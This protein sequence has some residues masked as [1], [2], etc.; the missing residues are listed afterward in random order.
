[1]RRISPS[2]SWQSLPSLSMATSQAYG[3]A[4]PASTS[5]WLR[6]NAAPCNAAPSSMPPVTRAAAAAAGEP[7]P[8]QLDTVL[9][10]DDK[11]GGRLGVRPS[12][13]AVLDVSFNAPLFTHTHTHTPEH[14]SMPPLFAHSQKIPRTVP[15]PAMPTPFISVDSAPTSHRRLGCLHLLESALC[16]AVRARL[17]SRSPTTHPLGHPTLASAST[18]KAGLTSPLAWRCPPL[19]QPR[20]LQ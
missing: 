3:T 4:A 18:C 6:S 17:E 13:G 5:T 20:R 16:G 19:P 9:C 7:Q 10:H 12:P 8:D 11:S 15:S 2:A 1:M 14:L